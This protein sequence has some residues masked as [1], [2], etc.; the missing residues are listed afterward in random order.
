MNI[1]VVGHRMRS[2]YILLNIKYVQYVFFGTSSIF[3]A[4]NALPLL[5]FKN[6]ELVLAEETILVVTYHMHK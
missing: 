2:R 1:K 3:N 6:A 5:E 4:C